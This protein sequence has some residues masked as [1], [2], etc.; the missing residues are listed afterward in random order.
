MRRTEA[1]IRRH[2]A[3]INEFATGGTTVDVFADDEPRPRHPK[4]VH[5]SCEILGV[6][7]LGRQRSPAKTMSCKRPP[8]PG[9]KPAT[10]TSPSA[11]NSDSS[12]ISL[13][14]L[15]SDCRFIA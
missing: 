10:S 2:L 14:L 4:P 8:S 5:P 12:R 9:A 3:Q 13:P 11:A 7:Y 15:F 6:L 1:L